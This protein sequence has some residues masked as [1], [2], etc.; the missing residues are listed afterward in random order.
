MLCTVCI[1]ILVI[2]YVVFVVGMP[3]QVVGIFVLV[4]F[5]LQSDDLTVDVHNQ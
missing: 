1:Y 4:V 3:M 5:Q 2:N